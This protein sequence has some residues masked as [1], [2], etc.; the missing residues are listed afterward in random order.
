MVQIF[1]RAFLYPLK[2]SEVIFSR[3]IKKASG[4]K[5]VKRL[6]EIQNQLFETPVDKTPL[7]KEIHNL[8]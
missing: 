6:S 1:P 4:M 2:T 8:K 7:C 3:G 5:L